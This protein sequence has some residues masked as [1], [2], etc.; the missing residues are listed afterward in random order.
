MKKS[1][2]I[3]K[4]QVEESHLPQSKLYLKITGIPYFPNG[5]SQECLN[6]SN[7]ESALKQNHIFNGIKLALKPRVIKVLPKSDMSIIWIDIWGFQSG[8]K[9]KCLINRYFNFRGYIATIRSTNMN[10]G[11]SQYKNC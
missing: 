9:A 5:K 1:D 4:L 7:I 10:P 2:N 11:V 8:K 3:N 6:I